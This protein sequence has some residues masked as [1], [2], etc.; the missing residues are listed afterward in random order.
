MKIRLLDYG[1]GLFS[2][3]FEVFLAFASVLSGILFLTGQTKPTA[4]AL[5]LP[6]WEL[7]GWAWLYTIG[8]MLIILARI[9]LASAKTE[10]TLEKGSRIEA[11]GLVLF[12][13]S[14]GTYAMAIFALGFIGFYSGLI[15]ASF[16]AA[17][18]ARL[19][20]IRSQWKPYRDARK[21]EEE[22]R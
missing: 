18:F 2:Q 22:N 7:S 12:G 21:A 4:L 6:G 15:L 17:S 3:P 1:W 14:L 8:G 19:L 11:A 16:S 10:R 20:T 5:Q 13:T 9:M